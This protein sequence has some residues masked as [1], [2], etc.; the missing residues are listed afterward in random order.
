[1]R[2]PDQTRAGAS[3][4]PS[5]KH[6]LRERAL[7]PIR[8][9]RSPRRWD[10]LSW[11]TSLLLF[12][13]PLVLLLGSVMLRGSS[14]ASPAVVL[15]VTDRYTKQPLAGVQVVAGNQTMTSDEE[16]VVRL[17]ALEEPVLLT[18]QRDRYEP[19]H[20]RLAAEHDGDQSLALRPTTLEGTIADVQ[21]GAPLD[22]RLVSFVSAAGQGPP[23]TTGADG[24]YRLDNVP[25]DARVRVDGVDYGVV[26]EPIGERT[27][28]DFALKLSVVTGVVTDASGAPLEGATIKTAQAEAVTGADGAYKLTGAGDATEVLVAAP[29]YEEQRLPVANGQA[30]AAALEPKQIKALYWGTSELSDPAELDARIEIADRTE[31]NAVVID[32]KEDAIFY[33]TQVPFFRGIDGMINPV[34]DPKTVIAKLHERGI[35]AIARMVIFKDPLVAEARP[36]LAVTDDVTGGSW[37]DSIGA[38]WVNAFNQELWQ[39]NADLAVELANLGFDEV[40]YDY[41]RFPSDGDLTTANFGPDYSQEARRGAIRGALETARDKLRPTGVAFAADFFGIVALFDDDQ[42]IGQYLEDIVP[43]VDYVCLMA[44]PSHYE[45]GNIRDANGEPLDP[46]SYPYETIK[47]TLDRVQERMPDESRLK[48]RPW[49]QDF[50]EYEYDQV[51]A[52]IR[53]AEEFGTSGWMIWGRVREEMYQPEA[54]ATNPAAG[55][56]AVL[57]TGAAATSR[58]RTR[59]RHGDRA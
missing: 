7:A 32:V 58:A 33:D 3:W 1:M 46:N 42:G 19:M 5:G 22:G 45:F 15:R 24:V 25:P 18:V 13:V 28:V 30:A 52:Q 11:R 16:G 53:A 51:R 29:G 44:Y 50:Y 43:L 17:P 47:F 38:A 23:V 35:Y 26:E 39:A 9:T 36:D 10:R 21:S 27:R 55:T 6:L 48:L 37:R 20:G 54:S 4:R 57:A 41:I 59:R 14:S 2:A 49:L 56:A 8:G 31:I 34:Y 40:Q 12:C